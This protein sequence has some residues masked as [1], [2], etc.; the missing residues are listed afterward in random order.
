[1]SLAAPCGSRHQAYFRKPFWPQR[2]IMAF[3]EQESGVFQQQCS[4]YDQ[5]SP[6]L[7]CNH[8]ALRGLSTW[9]ISFISGRLRSLCSCVVGLAEVHASCISWCW[10]V[11]KPSRYIFKSSTLPSFEY[12]L[13]TKQH[14][15]VLWHQIMDHNVYAN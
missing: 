10:S 4:K 8:R 15:I 9:K 5:T 6:E 14:V 11:A 1:M 12:M 2:E 13:F 3:C 7:A